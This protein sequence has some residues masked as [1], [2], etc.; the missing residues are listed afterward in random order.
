MV[1]GAVPKVPAAVGMAIVPM[2]ADGTVV[3]VAGGA[4]VVALPGWP[5]ALLAFGLVELPQAV[6]SKAREA[7]ST[8]AEIRVQRMRRWPFVG[9]GQ[10]KLPGNRSLLVAR[11]DHGTAGSVPN[12][13]PRQAGERKRA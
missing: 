7:V 1:G 9:V 4:V 5:P 10:S 11:G 8:T 3:V 6:A 12:Q 2:V 13:A